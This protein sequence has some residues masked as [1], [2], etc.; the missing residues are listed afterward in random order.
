MSHSEEE[1]NK[2][3]ETFRKRKSI[4][5]GIFLTALFLM[6]SITLLAFPSWELFGMPKL[7]W[8]PFFYIIMFALIISSSVFWR[9]PACNGRLG[10]IFNTRYCSKCGVKF[11]DEK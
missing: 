11:S 1:I 10:D 5:I 7:T 8:A 2:Y 6:I 4:R 3:R 9:C